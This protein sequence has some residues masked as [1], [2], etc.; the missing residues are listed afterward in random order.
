MKNAWFVSLSPLLS[1]AAANR[2][3]QNR[4]SRLP[5]INRKHLVADEN[6]VSA[7]ART[8]ERLWR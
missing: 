8:L 3:L 7:F 6:S 1:L 4:V 2:Q 5:F